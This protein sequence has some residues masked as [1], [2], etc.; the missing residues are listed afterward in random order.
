MVVSLR[1]PGLL[2]F[3]VVDWDTMPQELF[4][5][6]HRHPVEYSTDR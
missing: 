3:F 2:S 4:A 5:L 6:Q 1:L